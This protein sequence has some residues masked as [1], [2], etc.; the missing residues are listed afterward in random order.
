MKETSKLGKCK[1]NKSQ[2]MHYG[3]NFKA[4]SVWLNTHVPISIPHQMHPEH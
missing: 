3:P 4:M 1:I 2:M